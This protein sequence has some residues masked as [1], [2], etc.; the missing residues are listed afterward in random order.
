VALTGAERQARYM[1]RKRGIPAD[2]AGRGRHRSSRRNARAIESTIAAL[3]RAGRLEP[4]DAALVA[5]ARTTAAALDRADS[6]YLAA[7]VSRAYLEAVGRLLDR[8]LDGPDPIDLFV[9]SLRLPP[10]VGDAQ[11]IVDDRPDVS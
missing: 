7:I 11:P 10:S 1:A 9:A 5:A 3:R 4:V 6:P 2:R 8:D